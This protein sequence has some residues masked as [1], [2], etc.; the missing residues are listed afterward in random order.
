[1]PPLET[2]IDATGK[3]IKAIGV[4]IALVPVVAIMTGLVA[5]PPSLAQLSKMLT[6]MATAIGIITIMTLSDWIIRISNKRAAVLLMGA[7]LVGCGLATYYWQFAKR[8]VVEFE[9]GST[10]QVI[11]PMR[12]SA[13]IKK[14]VGAYG[15][16]YLE[17]LNVSP[18]KDR[19]LS[20][21]DEQNASAAILILALLVLSQ[22]L[23]VTSVVGGAW[24]L[25][26]QA[27]EKKPP[28]DQAPPNS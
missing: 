3:I 14:I 13:E 2:Q 9:R 12:P 1:M 15:D 10:E 23:L 18:D 22:M 24:R 26:G 19:L 28:N 7:A 4:L 17:A 20:L 21:I 8:H 5:I 11:L 25:A 27:S 6:F 16:D